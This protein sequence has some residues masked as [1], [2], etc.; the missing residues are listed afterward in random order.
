MQRDSLARRAF[1]H[2]CPEQPAL[3]S[4]DT[5]QRAVSNYADAI[6]HNRQAANG[7]ESVYTG[8]PGV[9]YSLLMCRE[10]ERAKYFLAPTSGQ[11]QAGSWLD[12]TARCRDPELPTSLLCGRAGVLFVELYLAWIESAGNADEAAVQRLS[13][14]YLRIRTADCSSNEWLYGKAGMPPRCRAQGSIKRC[15]CT[16][17]HTHTLCMHNASHAHLRAGYLWGLLALKNQ[18]GITGAAVDEKL[19]IVA[20]EVLHAGRALA[21]ARRCDPPLMYRCATLNCL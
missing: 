17:H 12:K 1:P 2:A 5:R 21:A 13:A 4:E 18:L 15:A 11:H 3:L 8:G 14:E 19:R 10:L 16:M 20:K 9:A 6:W 7:D